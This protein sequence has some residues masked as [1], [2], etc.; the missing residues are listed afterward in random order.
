MVVSCAA[1]SPAEPQ[2]PLI[3]ERLKISP[4]LAST[5]E[6][7]RAALARKYCFALGSN[8]SGEA[9][10]ARNRRGEFEVTAGANAIN[11]GN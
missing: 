3:S 5:K 6:S 9:A 1:V 8:G 2:A 10:W 11:P 4:T 7:S